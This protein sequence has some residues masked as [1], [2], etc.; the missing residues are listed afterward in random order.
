[1]RR[2]VALLIGLAMAMTGSVGHSVANDEGRVH[3]VQVV[4]RKFTFEPAIIQVTAGEPVLLVIRSADTVHGFAIR[5][6]KIDVQVP[7]GGEGVTVAFTAPPVGR[8]EIA[9]DEF[10]GSGHGQMKAALVSVNPSPTTH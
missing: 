9:C 2:S 6:L 10:C 8:Y 3:L 4:A 5:D 1:M 7:R